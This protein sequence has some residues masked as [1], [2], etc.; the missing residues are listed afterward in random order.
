LAKAFLLKLKT[1]F[2]TN[3]LLKRAFPD[4]FYANPLKQ[5]PKWNI[6]DGLTLKRKNVY[7]E[8]SV[9]AWGITD[10]MPTGKHF[11]DLVYDDL[12]TEKS[13]STPEQM[14]KLRD[15]FQ[16]SQYLGTRGG[17]ARIAGTIYHWGDLYCELEKTGTWNVR[18][19]P[20]LTNE[21]DFN[22]GVL[23][24]NDELLRKYNAP[25][26]GKYIFSCQML[27]NPI[28]PDMQRFERSW[29]RTYK[30]IEVRLNKYIIVD[31]A[32]EKKKTSDYTAIMVVGVDSQNKYFILDMVRDKLG[33]RERWEKILSLVKKHNPFHVGYEKYGMQSDIEYFNQMMQQ[34]GVY[35]TIVSLGGTT[36]KHDRIMK[37]PSLFEAGRIFLPQRYMQ[38]QRDILK[39]FIEDEYVTAPYSE[40]D[41]MMDCLARVLDE[42]MEIIFP[43]FGPPRK[44]KAAVQY[45]PYDS[46]ERHETW[47]WYTA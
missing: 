14:K 8:L 10:G 23:L 44:E 2:E 18:K 1:T 16:L 31:P 40:H 29:L 39:E 36:S 24:T 6:D 9:E 26:V 3:Q 30:E 12:V 20:A 27:L 34:T 13:V 33:L 45:D 25:G 11:T 38:G 5:S 22:S 42:K 43:G 41:D 35:F 7:N 15:C 17:A 19:Y 47:N 28:S 21:K 37:L 4:I 46:R 32:N